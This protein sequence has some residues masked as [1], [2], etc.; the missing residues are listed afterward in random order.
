MYITPENKRYKS[1]TT[2]LNESKSDEAINKLNEWRESTGKEIA[3]YIFLNSSIIGKATH[4]LNENYVNMKLES[5]CNNLMARSHHENFKPNM[6]KISKVYGTELIVYSDV[7]QLGGTI[8]CVGVY[9]GKLSIIDYKTKRS[10]QKDEYIVD[11]FIQTA[12]YAKMFKELT[13]NKKEI[14]QLVIL[15]SSE[16]N[17]IQEFIGNPTDYENLINERL[18]KFKEVIKNTCG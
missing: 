13:N 2:M 8:D 7:M 16:T 9:N 11:Y 1:V 5:P 15:T 17:T 6:D 3:D 4:K 18:L 14:K 12:I 10:K